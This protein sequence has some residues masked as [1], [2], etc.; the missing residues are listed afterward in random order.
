MPSHK[1]IQRQTA[2][3][4]FKTVILAICNIERR[5]PPSDTTIAKAASRFAKG[6]LSSRRTLAAIIAW[7]HTTQ[8][9]TA[10]A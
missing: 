9:S 7:L 6:R 1:P 10:P 8:A 3:V 4:D 5:H 2:E